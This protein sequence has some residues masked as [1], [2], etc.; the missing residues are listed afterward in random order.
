VPHAHSPE[1]HGQL[2]VLLNALTGV[3]DEQEAVAQSRSL[4]FDRRSNSHDMRDNF[5]CGG[6]DEASKTYRTA[7]KP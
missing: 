5:A 7:V 1:R 6:P 4:L 2:P 3:L